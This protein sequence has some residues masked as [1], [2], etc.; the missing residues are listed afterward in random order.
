[1]ANIKLN[2]DSLKPRR[3]FKRHAIQPGHN[4]YRVLPPFGSEE[5]H[6][7]YPYKRWSLA[8]LVDP[9]SGR[10][11]PF[12]VP[13][14]E[15]DNPD[16]VT[17]FTRALADKIERAK[18]ETVTAMI[19]KGIPQDKAE[20]TVRVKLADANKLVWETR[21]K[22]GFFYNACNKAGEVGILELKKTAH[23][24][25]KAEMYQYIKDYSQDPTALTSER[26]DSG[27]WFDFERIGEKGDKNTEYKVKKNQRKMKDADG[28]IVFRDDRE[29]LPEHVA[30]NYESLGYDIY[31]LYQAVT[32][33]ELYAILMFNLREIVKT[34]PFARVDGFDPDL[35]DFGAAEAAA[36]APVEQPV[37]VAKTTTVKLAGLA[38]E[39]PD[40]ELP[41]SKA[42]PTA[43][44]PAPTPATPAKAA[45]VKA[46][47]LAEDDIVAMA[48]SFLNS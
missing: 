23:D 42:A 29:A 26:D 7:N 30:Q 1:M 24:A 43:A 19:A 13:Q 33:E 48:D 2:T 31:G 4:I 11:R 41:V 8:W 14:F 12:A 9:Q 36:E 18:T 47:A 6:N 25:L 35:F 20:E 3:E 10:R 46:P 28:Q 40:F 32:R 5:L 15:K 34:V 17:A 21:P 22:S 16:P 45:P 39:E 27:V 44:K 37:V 38:E